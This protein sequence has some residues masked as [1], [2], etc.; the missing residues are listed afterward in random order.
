[1]GL[2]VLPASVLLLALLA[3]PAG[4]VGEVPQ[5]RVHEGADGGICVDTTDVPPGLD[6]ECRTYTLEDLY[7]EVCDPLDAC[8]AQWA[9]DL[10]LDAAC[11]RTGAACD[12]RRDT[13][14]DEVLRC[15]PEK[16]SPD[17]VVDSLR[18]FTLYP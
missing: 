5:A 18:H 2:R 1:M 4:A 3:T 14:L 17:W 8:V 7:Q 13:C 15:Q 9:I 10:A 6:P 12:W 11:A 16:L